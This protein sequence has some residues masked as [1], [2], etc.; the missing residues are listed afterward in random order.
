[1]PVPNFEDTREAVRAAEERLAR[2]RAEEEALSRRRAEMLT[3]QKD[4]NAFETDL[5]A[6][7]ARLRKLEDA[8]AEDGADARRCAASIHKTSQL[9]QSH[10][11]RLDGI[12]PEE[13]TKSRMKSELDRAL[14]LLADVEHDTKADLE[15]LERELPKRTKKIRDGWFSRVAYGVTS[16]FAF[17]LPLLVFISVAVILV[18]TALGLV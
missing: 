6:A 2:I 18:L 17:V 8:L 12:H 15:R 13:W 4:V 11:A 9:L 16:A 1:M 10:L 3:F 5:V 14:D 7:L